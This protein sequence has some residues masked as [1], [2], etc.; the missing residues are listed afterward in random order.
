VQGNTFTLS[1]NTSSNVT[2]KSSNP[3][4]ISVNGTTATINGKGTVTIT[5]S[6]AGDGNYKPAVSS[7]VVTVQ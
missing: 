6:L 1:A 4:I 3:H 2:F 5:A 7:V